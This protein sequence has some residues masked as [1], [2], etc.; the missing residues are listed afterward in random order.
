LADR[1]FC[2][3]LTKPAN[4]HLSFLSCS[5]SAIRQQSSC[6]IECVG[7]AHIICTIHNTPSTQWS[8]HSIDYYTTS[9]TTT[10]TT[11]TMTLSQR[12]E[13]QRVAAWIRKTHFISFRQVSSHAATLQRW[14]ICRSKFYVRGPCGHCCMPRHCCCGAAADTALRNLLIKN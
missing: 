14:P 1:S 11:T 7:V 5:T 6:C 3:C 8:R 10:T 9:T 2:S 13:E 4:T 12:Q